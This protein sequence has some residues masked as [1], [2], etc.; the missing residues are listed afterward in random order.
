MTAEPVAGRYDSAARR[1]AKRSGRQRGCWVYIPH[2]ELVKTG[3]GAPDHLPWY[4]VWGQS[5]GGVF[6]R[7]YRE[8]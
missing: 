8:A 7:L 4:R 1:R 2:E 6:I 3:H 5:R